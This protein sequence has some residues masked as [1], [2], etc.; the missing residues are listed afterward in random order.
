[1][2]KAC[3]I[4]N[5]PK[6]QICIIFTWKMNFSKLL[7]N[8]GNM[9]YRCDWSQQMAAFPWVRFS[10]RFLGKKEF[11]LPT[12]TTCFLKGGCLIVLSVCYCRVFTL[13]P[14]QESK[15]FVF[16]YTYKP[17]ALQERC[18]PDACRCG[19]NKWRFIPPHPHSQRGAVPDSAS[20][21]HLRAGILHSDTCGRIVWRRA[22]FQTAHQRGTKHGWR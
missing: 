21:S 11:F 16:I 6:S 12:V 18:G 5:S 2:K 22:S 4:I 10:Q 14:L 20:R 19:H 17:S 13:K 8:Y 15:Q 3:Y 1:M 7:T 9:G